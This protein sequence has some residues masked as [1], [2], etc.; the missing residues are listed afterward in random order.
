MSTDGKAADPR[1]IGRRPRSRRSATATGCLPRLRRRR[2]RRAIDVRGGRLARC[3]ALCRRRASSRVFATACAGA[4]FRRRSATLERIP[5]TAH[6]WT[7]RTG[8]RCSAR[9][10]PEHDFS[11]QLDVAERLIAAFPGMLLYWHH[12]A[13]AGKRIATTTDAQSTA[14]ISCFSTAYRRARCTSARWTRR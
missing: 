14:G 6:R 13:T 11:R 2:S 3:A 7:L 5:P 10:E 8:A 4:S 12:F 1:D 9:L